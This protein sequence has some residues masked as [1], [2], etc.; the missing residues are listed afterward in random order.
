M[1]NKI[2]KFIEV[3]LPFCDNVYGDGTGGGGGLC[4]GEVGVTGDQKCFNTLNFTHDCQDP[5]N[6]AASTK[7]LRFLQ[8]DTGFLPANIDGIP[9]LDDFKITGGK[10]SPGE[11]FGSRYILNV[12]LF[13]C[14]H[15]DTGID[16]YVSER[17]YIAF[18]T[19]TFLGKFRARFP[20]IE[21]RA[22]RAYEG[23]LGQEYSEF[24]CYNFIIDK[25]EGPDERLKSRIIATDFL[26]LLN[27]EKSLAPAPS[28]GYLSADYAS[29]TTNITLTPSGIGD[30]EYPTSGRVAIGKELFDFTRTA[31]TDVLTISPAMSID[32]KSGE[33]VQQT[34]VYAP[35]SAGLILDDLIANQSP[36]STAYTD[37]A[38]WAA[39]ISEVNPFNYERE[40]VKPTPT[41]KLVNELIEQVGLV[42]RAN[43]IT[44]KVDVDVLRPTPAT[45]QPVTALQIQ[46][47]SFN[48]T[49]Q[50][51]K[52]YDNAICYYD[53]RDP[54][55]S[56]EP[57]SYYSGASY[58]A[59]DIKY[60]TINTKVIYSQWIVSGGFSAAQAVATRLVARYKRPPRMFEFD[61]FGED[62]RSHGE[63]IPLSHDTFI[64][65]CTGEPDNINAIVVSS[66]PS[67][68]LSKYQA[69]E[70]TIDA[71]LYDGDI[72]IPFDYDDLNINLRDKYNAII[73]SGV[74][75][76]SP[77]APDVIFI[78]RSGVAIGSASNLLYSIVDGTWPVGFEPKLLLESGSYVVGRGGD[79]GYGGGSSGAGKNGGP[80]INVTSGLR[81][82]NYGTIGGG[83][84]GGGGSSTIIGGGSN[85]GGGGAGKISGSGQALGTIVSGGIIAGSLAGNGGDL[86][87]NGTTGTDPDRIHAAGGLAGVAING[88]SLVTYINAGTILGAQIG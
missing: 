43:L 73:V 56:D 25:M 20:Y 35:Q 39:K 46:P 64:Q 81:I 6:Y 5:T 15:S 42:V 52:R 27:D 16:P 11:D 51:E 26:K 4:Q 87:A 31:T 63:V 59:I 79:A 2:V 45:G 67:K 38:T 66:L 34:L 18:E 83:G 86:G 36:L 40:I 54:F 29:T 62:R 80:S 61:L 76:T 21:G 30:E 1:M 84:G 24:T 23:F 44:N 9:I 19:G 70:Y 49:D 8:R 60:P 88:A 10:M 47:S 14:R 28:S 7:T 75:D 32:H 41:R 33:V 50:P 82:E 72:I 74:V 37:G 78:V 68:K 85:Y 22:I 12:D 3:D 17:G 77:G 48:Q 13:D 71:G 69:E 58:L 55:T 57:E 53:K 65:S